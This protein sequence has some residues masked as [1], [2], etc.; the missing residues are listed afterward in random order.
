MEL[1]EIKKLSQAILQEAS[2]RIVGNKD[3]ITKMVMAVYAQGHVLLEGV[4]GIAKTLMAST[5]SELLGLEFKRVQFTPDLLPSDILGVNVYNQKTSDFEFIKGPVFT[6]FLLCDEINR[7]PPKTQSALLEAM[8]EKQVSIEGVSMPLPQPFFVVATQNPIEQAGTYRLPEAQMDRFIMRLL[9]TVPSKLDEVRMLK[10]KDKAV[11]VKVNQVLT[12]AQLM[13][14]QAKIHEITIS[15]QVMNYIV[16]I[17]NLTREVE[18]IELGASPRA[19]I[20]LMVLG[21]TRAAI[22]GRDYVQPDDIKYVA[23]DVL[24]HRV[25][26]SHE[27]EL[28]RIQPKDIIKGILEE[29]KVVV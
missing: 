12:K 17:V 13:E 21:K 25:I 15:E 16:D 19:S 6:N 11:N 28:Q 24:N 14:I 29:A 4:P 20:A 3:I 1:E 2:K 26:L 7:A 9:V 8:Q 27:A 23:F 22:M 5:L 10:I 18:T